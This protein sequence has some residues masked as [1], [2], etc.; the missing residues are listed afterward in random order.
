[1]DLYFGIL[2][3]VVCDVIPSHPQTP[4][5]F[6]AESGHEEVMRVLIATGADV[7]AMDVRCVE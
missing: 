6:A 1:M 2:D 7:N 4:L 5:H 3:G